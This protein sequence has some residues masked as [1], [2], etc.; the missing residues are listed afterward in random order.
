MS[1]TFCPAAVVMAPVESVWELLSETTLYDEWMDVRTERIVPEGNASP[2][3]MIYAKT[4]GLGRK[5]DVTFRVDAVKPE[6]HQIQMHVTLPLGIVN[7]VTI[8]CTA[9]DPTSCRVQYG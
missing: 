3:Q 5:W 1:F 8:T 6:K 9:I 2:G 7:H 4:S